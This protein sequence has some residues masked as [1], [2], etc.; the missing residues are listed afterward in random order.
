VAATRTKL[1]F[2]YAIPPFGTILRESH[3]LMRRV[4]HRKVTCNSRD[5]VIPSWHGEQGCVFFGTNISRVSAKHKKALLLYL[6][7]SSYRLS[8]PE[9]LSP[10][11]S[12]STRVKLDN[13]SQTKAIKIRILL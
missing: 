4:V 1:I 6:G 9:A 5:R 2:W 11:P 7:K 12:T 3:R 8:A 13:T 10:S